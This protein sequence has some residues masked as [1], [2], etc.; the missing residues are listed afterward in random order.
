M[1]DA[2]F[3]FAFMGKFLQLYRFVQVLVL[4]WLQTIQ[5]FW[6]T[7]TSTLNQASPAAQVEA[8]WGW[9]WGWG[10]GWGRGWGWGWGQ[11]W[12][13][14]WGRGWGGLRPILLGWIL[15]DNLNSGLRQVEG[16]SS[17]RFWPSKWTHH[18]IAIHDSSAR[19]RQA[20]KA[21][22]QLGFHLHSENIT[23]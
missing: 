3:K 19:L 20:Y 15:L 16:W 8:G 4:L 6:M 23:V 5:P 12:G 1:F 22:F 21:K 9:G 13:Q 2:I 11:G 17:V 7:S 18:C 14:G 10:Q